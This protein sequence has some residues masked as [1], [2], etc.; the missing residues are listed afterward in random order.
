[1]ELKIFDIEISNIL[2]LIFSKSKKNQI[3]FLIL[4]LKDLKL[5]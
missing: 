5:D 3:Y 1:M 2:Y 4:N